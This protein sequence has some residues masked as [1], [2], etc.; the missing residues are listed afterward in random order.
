MYKVNIFVTTTFNLFQQTEIECD[1]DEECKIATNGTIIDDYSVVEEGEQRASVE[2][3]SRHTCQCRPWF[4]IS[5]HDRNKCI[6]IFNGV[7]FIL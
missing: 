5:H 6:K 1:N 2:C 4:G 3:S 7:L